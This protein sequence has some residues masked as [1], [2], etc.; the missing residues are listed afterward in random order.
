M[1]KLDT[2]VGGFQQPPQLKYSL[3]DTTEI[4]CDCGNNSFSENF[5]IRQ[6]SRILTGAPKDSLVTIPVFSCSK[7]G[8]ILEQFIPEEL[9]SV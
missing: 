9:K 8:K 2:N 5:L 6:L 1:N 3:K 7:C 4:K